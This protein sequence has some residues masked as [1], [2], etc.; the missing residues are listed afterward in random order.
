MCEGLVPLCCCSA[1]KLCPILKRPHGLQHTRF[2]CPSL[3]PGVCSSLCPWSQWC[4]LTISSFATLFS[5]CLDLSQHQGLFQWVS[6]SHQV[7]KVLENQ[8][9]SLQRIFRVDFLSDRHT[10]ITFIGV[11]VH[12][13]WIT[14]LNEGCIAVSS[15]WRC[16]SWFSENF[17]SFVQKP[18]CRHVWWTQGSKPRWIMS[19]VVFSLTTTVLIPTPALPQH[20][21]PTDDLQILAARHLI[22]KSPTPN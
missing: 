18:Q 2:P 6:S 13:T 22:L 10:G 8:H 5:F 9:Q 17:S 4:F 12:F 20:S 19:D 1:T 21:W 15:G 16:R 11:S 7:A 3:S 14:T